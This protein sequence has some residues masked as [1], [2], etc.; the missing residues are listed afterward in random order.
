MKP[1]ALSSAWDQDWKLTVRGKFH[2]WSDHRGIYSVRHPYEESQT[3]D[4]VALTRKVTLPAAWQGPVVLS[5]FATDDHHGRD[6]DPANWPHYVGA[7]IFVGHR[8]AQA[9]VDGKVVWE[10]DVAESDSPGWKNGQDAVAYAGFYHTADLTG[11]VKPG[12][13]FDLELRIIDKVGSGVTLPGDRHQGHYWEPATLERPKANAWFDF[14]GW[15]GDVFLTPDPMAK[16]AQFA[17]EDR[18]E[19]APPEA[20]QPAVAG[21]VT[22]TELTITRAEA[23]PP[24]PYPLWGGV[25]MPPGLVTKPSQ[26]RLLDARGGEVAC[27]PQIVSRWP[28]DGSAQWVWI[29]AMAPAGATKL[30]MQCG[31]GVA[32][33]DAPSSL[34]VGKT[35][36]KVRISTGAATVVLTQG[37]PA[38]IE[39]LRLEGGPECGPVTGAIHQQMLGYLRNH[40]AWVTRLTVEERGPVRAAVKI[41]G[42]LKDD[43]GHSFGPFVARLW[44]WAGS[45]LVSL[46][47]RVFQQTDQVVAIV[48]DMLLEVAT[49]YGQDTRASFS[50]QTFNHPLPEGQVN[51]LELR[52]PLTG[53][54]DY[55]ARSQ[56]YGIIGKRSETLESGPHAPGWV[57]MRGRTAGGE[58]GGLACG[59]RWL[60]QQAP[61]S[62]TVDPRGITV[63]LFARRQRDDW[64]LDSPLLMMTRGEAK[65]HQVWLLPHDGKAPAEL[66]GQIERAWDARPC[67]MNGEWFSRSGVM[68]HFAQHNPGSFPEMDSFLHGW[69]KS[70]LGLERYGFRDF[71]ETAWCQNYRG[72]AANGLLEYFSSG[73]GDWQDYFE[74]VMSHNLDVDTIHYEP[75]HPDWVGAIRDYSPYHTTG[76]PSHSINT[77]CQDQFLHY[78]F[79]GEPDS[80]AEATLVADHIAQLGGDQGRSARQEGWP[81][82]QMS[83]AYLWTGD[84]KYKQAAENLFEFARKYTHPRRGGYDEV[85]SSF[86]NRGIVPFMTGYLGYG[87]MRYHEATGDE[88]AAKLIVALS[89]AT[90]SETSD[91]KGGFWYSPCPSGRNWGATSWTA[92]IGAMLAYSYRVTHDAWFAQQAQICYDR[93]GHEKQTTVSLDMAPTMGEMLAGMEL[94]RA[95]GDLK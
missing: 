3:G 59:V 58:D 52:D 69:D 46:S 19:L 40:Q 74:Q 10:Q 41:E 35:D 54:Y 71:R 63:G 13:S 53:T 89:E 26:I 17:L 49:P 64:A 82:A 20:A 55:A 95:R 4:L 62:L 76:G 48:D 33:Q 8:F 9:L 61:K 91:G 11:A 37:K 29:N 31:K 34:S 77:N 27:Q 24:I 66:L 22:A 45:P 1:I 51:E 93:L 81:M 36:D 75:D 7:D 42:E 78:Y 90:V 25:P 12:Q 32:R 68:G 44:A 84:P 21:D 92:L 28:G 39:S 72:R 6:Y 70:E 18:I 73:R 5:F 86:S 83:I 88:R 2:G 87:L 85:H 30:T 65:R 94:A 60:W 38:V 43:Q 79:A 67:L 14:T 15:W 56:N 23:L 16:D 80:L 57:D 47:Y 50:E